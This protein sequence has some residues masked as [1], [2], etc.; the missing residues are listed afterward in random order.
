MTRVGGSGGVYLSVSENACSF[1]I[2]KKNTK[3][4]MYLTDNILT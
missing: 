2:E 3:P 4:E 1:T